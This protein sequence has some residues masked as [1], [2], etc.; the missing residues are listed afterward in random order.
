M[1]KLIIDKMMSHPG[2][3]E[4]TACPLY[5]GDSAYPILENRQRLQDSDDGAVFQKRLTALVELSE[6]N[7]VHFPVRQLL[8]SPPLPSASASSIQS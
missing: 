6:Q 4:C 8:A 7:G 1:I 3:S 2:W 5:S